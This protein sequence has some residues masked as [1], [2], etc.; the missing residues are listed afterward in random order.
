M[1]ACG[2][3]GCDRP[4]KANGYCGVH[5]ERV[6][7]TGRTDLFRRNGRP[8]VPVL[9]R[10]LTFVDKRGE[11][12]CWPWIGH[13]IYSG[14]GHFRYSEERRGPAHRFAYELFMGPIPP[15]MQI[16]H[17][18]HTEADDCPPGP[19]EHR[20]CV[21]PRHLDVVTCAENTRRRFGRSQTVS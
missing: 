21:N 14:Y 1:R 3:E 9:D 15:D 11:D 10:F 17:R 12:E 19:C 20:R 8:P 16:D 6:R 5:G 13:V 7:R 2:V 4:H 18:C